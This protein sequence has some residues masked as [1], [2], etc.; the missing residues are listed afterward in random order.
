MEETLSI[1]NSLIKEIEELKVVIIQLENDIKKIK[2]W[3]N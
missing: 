2:E 1:I 3:R